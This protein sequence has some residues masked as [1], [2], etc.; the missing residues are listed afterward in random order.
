MPRKQMV[1]RFM[2]VAKCVCRC[3]LLDTEK[4]TKRT[5]YISRPPANH[6]DLM[7]RAAKIID[8]DKVRVLDI[9]N[10][11]YLRCLYGLDLDTYIRYAQILRS[12]AIDSSTDAAERETQ[13][14]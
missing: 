2:T 10:V 5:V 6:K 12:E 9:V 4:V 1:R 8:C 13:D 7:K 11:T 14:E 3:C